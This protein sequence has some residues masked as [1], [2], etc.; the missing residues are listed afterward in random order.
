MPIHIHIHIHL[1]RLFHHQFCIK[2]L[3]RHTPCPATSPTTLIHLLHILLDPTHRHHPLLPITTNTTPLPQLLTLPNRTTTHR[4]HS[5]LLH[6]HHRLL[7]HHHTSTIPTNT[8]I[9]THIPIN[10]II[11]N[12]TINNKSIRIRA[13]NQI[14]I[15]I[16]IEFMFIVNLLLL[17]F[18]SPFSPMRLA[19]I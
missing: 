9:N 6:R 18:V 11:N 2:L 12:I 16:Q 3:S 4:I 8:P 7:I 17:L 5:F 15:Q 1:R 10:I 14:Q 13:T 19:G